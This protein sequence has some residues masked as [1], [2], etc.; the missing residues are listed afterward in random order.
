[1]TTTAKSE[2][3]RVL[4]GSLAASS[5]SAV[6]GLAWG[7][8]SGSGAILF[9][10]LF[11]AL[12]L[13][14]LW[15]ALRATRLLGRPEDD[16]FQFGFRHLEP[17]V[18]ALR[19]LALVLVCCSAVAG[20]I[21]SI[22]EGGQSIDQPSVLAFALFSLALSGGLLGWERRVLARHPSVA[23]KLDAQEW[24]LSALLALGILA[25]W[26]T[27]HALSA[28]GH[29]AAARLIDP[30]LV[31]LVVAAVV[32]MPLRLLPGAVRDV[33]LIAPEAP[34]QARFRAVV[35]AEAAAA[36]LPRWKLH[37]A[38]LGEGFDVELNFLVDAGFAMP[39]GDLDRLRARLEA[40]FGLPPQR[41]WLT[42][43]FTSEPRWL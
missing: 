5:V 19:A 13:V 14:T 17:L 26:L 35:E 43:T 22:L 6:A 28:A 32:T 38:R 18:T 10:G 2:V 3:E 37:L 39:A 40:G 8:G 15:L 1:M 33:L 16:R 34:V 27:A 42:V 30:A 12:G 9:D 29:E 11:S 41:L 25:G 24:L 21:A 7:I 31:L 4:A 20:A 36:G 23:L